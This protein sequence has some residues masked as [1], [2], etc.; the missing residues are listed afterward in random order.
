MGFSQQMMRVLG[1][2]ERMG[3]HQKI[4]A[5]GGKRKIMGGTNKAALLTKLWFTR[6]W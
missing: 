2:L 1:N 5:L 4:Q 3:Q 6:H